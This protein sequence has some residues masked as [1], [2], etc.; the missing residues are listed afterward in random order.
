M[1]FTSMCES[2]SFSRNFYIRT[3]FIVLCV[4]PIVNEPSNP[5]RL[6]TGATPAVAQGRYNSFRKND[7]T[8]SGS[9][10]IQY[11]FPTCDMSAGNQVGAAFCVLDLKR[12]FSFSNRFL[13]GT[14]KLP[15]EVLQEKFQK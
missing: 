4:R 10:M 6:Y 9:K 8:S 14:I 7:G 1:Y 2:L 11:P 15:Y 5:L 12:R 3:I 13:N